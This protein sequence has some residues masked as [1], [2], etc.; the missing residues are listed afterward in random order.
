MPFL[1]GSQSLQVSDSARVAWQKNLVG[2]VLPQSLSEL[3]Q[4]SPAFWGEPVMHFPPFLRRR[5]A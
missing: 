1:V 2:S 5:P 4:S 3:K